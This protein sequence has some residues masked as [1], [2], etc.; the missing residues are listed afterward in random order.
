MSKIIVVIL[1]LFFLGCSENGTR[2]G[3]YRLSADGSM[4]IAYIGK[5][6]AIVGL[7]GGTYYSLVKARFIGSPD[8][9]ASTGDLIEN[10][11]VDNIL[12][13]GSSENCELIY[14]GYLP[15]GSLY[16]EARDTADLKYFVYS[17]SGIRFFYNHNEM[18]G[19]FS[20]LGRE[21]QLNPLDFERLAKLSACLRK[22]KND[23]TSQP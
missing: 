17:K 11:I 16:L 1:V 7:R 14:G 4:V 2:G 23:S 10:H 6:H 15:E 21:I 19:E 3:D 9:A 8:H 18:S 5:D 22:K 20:R 12:Y 13:V